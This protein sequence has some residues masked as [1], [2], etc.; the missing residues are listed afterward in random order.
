MV[1]TGLGYAEHLAVESP[2]SRYEAVMAPGGCDTGGG[3]P[4]TR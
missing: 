2:S 1:E 3:V 4:F